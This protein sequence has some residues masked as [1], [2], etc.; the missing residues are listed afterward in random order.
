MANRNRRKNSAPMIGR[1]A[2]LFGNRSPGDG[3]RPTVSVAVLRA[4]PLEF[5]APTL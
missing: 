5:I 2:L 3:Y 1:F 4:L